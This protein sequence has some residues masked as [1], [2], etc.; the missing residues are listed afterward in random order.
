MTAYCYPHHR[1]VVLHGVPGGIMGFGCS[2]VR[3]DCLVSSN[4]LA[5]VSSINRF[6]DGR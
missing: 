6:N 2:S 4:T 5:A 3:D 1:P